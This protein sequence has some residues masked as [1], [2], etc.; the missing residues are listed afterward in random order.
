MAETV[1]GSAPITHSKIAY[2]WT[3]SEGA[4]VRASMAETLPNLSI[5]EGYMANFTIGASGNLTI[6][7]GTITSA[8][9]FVVA[10]SSGSDATSNPT[11]EVNNSGVTDA[12]NFWAVS[13]GAGITQVEIVN[14]DAANTLE[15]IVMVG[16]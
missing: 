6:P 8:K 16:E 10:V 3:A 2:T 13:G 1:T 11:I 15:I 12:F 4:T 14:T 7:L 5:T 9:V